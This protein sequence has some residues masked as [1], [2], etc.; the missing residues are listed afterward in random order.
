MLKIGKIVNYLGP[1]HIGGGIIFLIGIA[2]F[3]I[4]IVLKNSDEAQK[5]FWILAL[6]ISIIC[7]AFGIWIFVDLLGFASCF[8]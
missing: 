8:S 3:I 4:S 7:I 1:S 5:K 6:V 2:I